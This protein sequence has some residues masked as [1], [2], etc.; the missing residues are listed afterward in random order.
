MNKTER[1]H[2][3]QYLP[4]ITVVLLYLG[5]VIAYVAQHNAWGAVRIG[6][7]SPLAS[8]FLLL[9][10]VAGIWLYIFV[11]LKA[12]INNEEQPLR[13]GWLGFSR[14][15]TP[16]RMVG[17]V[18]PLLLI[19][20]FNSVYTS[21]KAMLGT[22]Q[23]FQFDPLLA[24][25]DAMLH[26]GVDPWRLTHALLPST[27]GTWLVDLAYTA[28]LVVLW[29]FI[30]WQVLRV[31]H[32]RQRQQFLLAYVLCWSVIGSLFAYL[33]ASAGPCY[34]DM[35]VEGGG[36]FTPLMERLQQM[37]DELLAYGDWRDL[38][39]L[40]GQAYLRSGYL[41]GEVIAGGGISAMPSMHLSM[42]TLFVLSAWKENK[43]LAVLMGAYALVILFG[44]VHLGW[45]Y[46]LDGYVAIALTLLLWYISG[47]LV[48]LVVK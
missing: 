42:A 40:N 30:V 3:L 16:R 33:L 34:Y 47:R 10:L 5:I 6:L 17:I 13:Q 45:H 22:V 20:V 2:Y 9:A 11:T 35:V 21:F 36:R 29:A 18:L 4:F 28:W 46:A 1:E 8:L 14:I 43:T 19:A 32:P 25:L 44:S 31:N 12:F 26:G 15:A 41:Q 24:R 27:A 48:G 39:A 37:K 7:Y 38:G 23:P